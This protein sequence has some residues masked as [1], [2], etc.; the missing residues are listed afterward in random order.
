MRRDWLYF[1]QVITGKRIGTP[2]G[3][4][5][6]GLL[7]AA[8]KGR[9]GAKAAPSAAEAAFT[10]AIMDGLKAVPFKEFAFFRSLF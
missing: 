4:G 6:G 2:P 7:Q 10:T 1:G 5:H 8:E 9:I 3:W